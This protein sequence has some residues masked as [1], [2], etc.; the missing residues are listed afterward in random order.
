MS[1]KTRP[2]LEL[3][4]QGRPLPSSNDWTTFRADYSGA[5]M[6]YFGQARPGAA[7]GSLVWQIMKID[8]SGAN[9]TSGKYPTNTAGAISSDFEFSWTARASYTYA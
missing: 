9:P 3:D 5:N 1:R 7:E 4:A 8:Y 6:I 2:F